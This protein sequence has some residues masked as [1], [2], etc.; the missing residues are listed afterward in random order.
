MQWR[1]S[2]ARLGTNPQVR[3]TVLSEN[4]IPSGRGEDA[5]SEGRKGGRLVLRL[6]CPTSEARE[7]R[8]AVE[9]SLAEARGNHRTAEDELDSFIDR[10]ERQRLTYEG[11]YDPEAEWRE[12]TRE[13]AKERRLT[14]R[15]LWIRFHLSQ[16]E[17]LRSTLQRMVDHHEQEAAKW[18]GQATMEKSGQLTT[19][20]P[21]KG[22]AWD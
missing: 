17:R 8:M 18:E 1:P 13:H 21:Q 19:Y 22:A 20:S 5:P 3:R 2:S 14:I 7:R 12:L 16:A 9:T 4:R 15:E 10:R 6:P 11:P